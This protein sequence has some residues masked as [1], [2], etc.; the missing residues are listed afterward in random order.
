MISAA[1]SQFNTRVAASFHEMKN[2]TPEQ[3]VP[4]RE[5]GDDDIVL[6]PCSEE[7]VDGPGAS[8]VSGVEEL[9][10]YRAG[11]VGGGRR[12]VH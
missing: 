10:P 7:S 1:G 3:I 2:H 6:T 9:G 11:A 8:A 12:Y 4:H 5:I